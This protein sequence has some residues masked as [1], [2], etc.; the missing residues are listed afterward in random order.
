MI[1]AEKKMETTIEKMDHFGE[2]MLDGCLTVSS[3]RKVYRL[4]EAILHSKKLG[5]P[6]SED[7]MKKYEV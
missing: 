5:R 2:E 6:L 7:E 4:R 1:V 3:N